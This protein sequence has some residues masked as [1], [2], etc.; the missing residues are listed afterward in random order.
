MVVSSL[1]NRQS[2]YNIKEAQRMKKRY[3]LPI[4]VLFLMIFT[5]T[6]LSA[7]VE[8]VEERT[9]SLSEGGFVSVE[10]IAGDI[11]IHSGDKE[12]VRMIATK[13]ARTS[14]RTRAEELIEVLEIEVSSKEDRIEV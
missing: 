3:F 11:L 9:F 5:A 1:G 6:A 2:K 14:S 13:W 7:Q 4:G 12:E 10:S 8:E